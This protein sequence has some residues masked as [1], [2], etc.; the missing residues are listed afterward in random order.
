MYELKDWYLECIWDRQDPSSA[1][2]KARGIVNGHRKL[3]DGHHI[4]TSRAVH[5]RLDRPKCRLIM[6]TRSGSCYELLFSEIDAD[7]AGLTRHAVRQMGVASDWLREAERMAEIKEQERREMADRELEDEEILLLLYGVS[8]YR[9]YYKRNGEI[10][11][12]EQ[13]SMGRHRCVTDKAHVQ[14]HFFR[15]DTL[16]VISWSD[17]LRKVKMYNAG[18]ANVSVRGGIRPLCCRPGE[19]LSIRKDWFVDMGLAADPMW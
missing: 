12:L 15:N 7:Y 19:L 14:F 17:G 18:Y 9:A 6:D 16:D 4:C 1:R 10:S 2:V 3:P 13:L 5:L 8:V 11:L